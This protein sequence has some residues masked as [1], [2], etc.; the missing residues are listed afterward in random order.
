LTRHLTI[1]TST[2]ATIR[3]TTTTASNH[4][5]REIFEVN[6]RLTASLNAVFT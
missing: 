2:T 6:T 3:T 1:T 4:I 5:A